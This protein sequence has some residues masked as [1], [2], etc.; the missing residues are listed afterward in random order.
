VKLWSTG[1][2]RGPPLCF[3][4][5]AG[6]CCCLLPA[7][8]GELKLA[9][10]E[11]GRGGCEGCAGENDGKSR[12]KASVRS[13]SLPRWDCLIGTVASSHFA[14]DIVASGSRVAL[15]KASISATIRPF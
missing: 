9:A 12:L 8:P 15:S 2:C 10:A 11:A 6:R 7:E 3:E 4:A 13:A 1:P 5:D 14:S